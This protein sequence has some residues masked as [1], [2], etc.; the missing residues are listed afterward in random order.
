MK[1]FF[2]WV[3]QKDLDLLCFSDRSLER[4]YFEYVLLEN[5]MGEREGWNE[6]LRQKEVNE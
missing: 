3:S 6:K 4:K 1:F 5:E 2:K